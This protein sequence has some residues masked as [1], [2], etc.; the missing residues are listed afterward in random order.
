MEFY[1]LNQILNLIQTT[2]YNHAQVNGYNFGEDFEIS[3]NEQ[4]NYPLV[5]T[6]VIDAVI[7]E[8]TL[9]INIELK[10]LDI[11]QTNNN[12]EKDVLSDCLSIIQDIYASLISYQYQDYFMLVDALQLTPMREALPDVVNGWKANFVFQLMQ[13]KNRC[14]IPIK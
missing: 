10:V 2:A 8:K 4:E 14:Q 1:T 12:N 11:V 7:A 5:W 3:A 13:D 9:N 6:N